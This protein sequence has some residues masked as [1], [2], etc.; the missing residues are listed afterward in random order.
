MNIR[1]GSPSAVAER[2][3]VRARPR[4]PVQR[5][6]RTPFRADLE[7]LR[8][9]AILLVVAAGVGVPGL[10][11]G[12]AGAEVFFVL[13][14]FLITGMLDRVSLPR[15]WAR[16][17]IRLLPSAALV[18]MLTVAAAWLWLPAAAVRGYA[19]DALAAAFGVGNVR[20]EPGSPFHHLW[21]LAV[22][23]Q[24]LLLWPLLIMFAGWVANRSG[25]LHRRQ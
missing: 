5:A 12:R 23:E 19:Y 1:A 20:A 14:G 15:F 25:S 21:A 9:V 18:I 4:V 17:A 10:G 8:A 11:R 16:R 22:T 7:G 2:S 3:G 24:F 13:S 6:G